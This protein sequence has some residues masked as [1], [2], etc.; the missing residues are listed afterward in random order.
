M[1]ASNMMTVFDQYVPESLQTKEPC[2][3]VVLQKWAK[4]LCKTR[5]YFTRTLSQMIKQNVFHFT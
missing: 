2:A 3:V 4:T 1:E 5:T